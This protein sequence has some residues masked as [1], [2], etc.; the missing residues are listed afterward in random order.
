MEDSNQRNYLK[1]QSYRYHVLTKHSLES[2]YSS[3]GSLDWKTQPDPF[4]VYEGAS[5]IALGRVFSTKEISLFESIKVMH[6]GQGGQPPDEVLPPPAVPA[7]LDFISNLLFHSMAISAW[8]QVKG[9][10][11]KWALRV[12][13][14]SGNLHPTEVHVLTN[15]ID[16]IGDGVYHYLAENH[17]LE[18]RAADNILKP[19]LQLIS[20]A[21]IEAPPVMLCLSSIFWREAWKYRDRA[22]RYCQLDLGHA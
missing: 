19:V 3:S 12:N 8:K 7:N 6:N 5:K 4:R 18:L 16:G 20:K 14:S 15:N 11:S 10:N 1:S 9:T 2:L 17:S 21:K 22:F 13:P